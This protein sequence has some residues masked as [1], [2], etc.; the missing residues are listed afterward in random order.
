MVGRL[1]QQE[2]IGLSHHAHGQDKPHAEPSRQLRDLGGL[3]VLGEAHIIQPVGDILVGQARDLTLAEIHRGKLLDL[4]Q[5]LV[6][7][8]DTLQVRRH[9]G[10]AS[11]THLVHQ[12]GLPGTVAA[13]HTVSV[14]LQQL[15]SGVTEQQL[16]TTVA[17]EQ[18]LHAAQRGFAFTVL[19]FRA[20]QLHHIL[21]SQGQLLPLLVIQEPDQSVVQGLLHSEQALACVGHG[22]AE[23]PQV[24][25][26]LRG[27]PLH[28]G[29]GLGHLSIQDLIGLRHTLQISL[30]H[31][32]VVGGKGLLEVGNRA[33]VPLG[34]AIALVGLRVPH[35]VLLQVSERSGGEG[36]L[37]GCPLGELPDPARHVADDGRESV[38]DRLHRNWP[39]PVD[40]PS[41]VV[42][43][44]RPTDVHCGQQTA[45]LVHGQG[46]LALQ[47]ILSPSQDLL[48]CPLHQ[49]HGVHST[50]LVLI[51]HACL[52]PTH[53]HLGGPVGEPPHHGLRRPPGGS[54]HV[55]IGLGR[56]GQ[57]RGEHERDEGAKIVL[58]QV[59]ARVQDLEGSSAQQ[60]A[61]IRLQA[62]GHRTCD[63]LL[64][65]IRELQKAIGEG[66]GCPLPLVNV[67]RLQA[68]KQPRT[69]LSVKNVGHVRGQVSNSCGSLP[70][71]LRGG[72][73]HRLLQ[74][75]QQQG[76]VGPDGILAVH[77][78]KHRPGNACPLLLG[79]VGSLPEGPL[80]DGHNEGQGPGVDVV[81]EGGVGQLAQ[82]G[83]CQLLLG[84]VLQSADQQGREGSDLRVVNGGKHLLA[85]LEGGVN[86]F[87]SDVL[88]R[89][90]HNGQHDGGGGGHR[91]AVGQIKPSPRNALDGPHL[92]LPLGGG[93]PLDQLRHHK[94]PN[95]VGSGLAGDGLA[96]CQGGRAGAGK[97]S[98]E[99]LG[100]HWGSPSQ[101]GD[102]AEANKLLFLILVGKLLLDLVPNTELKQGIDAQVAGLRPELAG[103]S[104]L[105]SLSAGRQDGGILRFSAVH[106]GRGVHLHV[107]SHPTVGPLVSLHN[108][109][110]GDSGG[111]LLHGLPLKVGLVLLDQRL[112][113]NVPLVLLVLLH[114]CGN[115]LLFL[116]AC[117][118]LHLLLQIVKLHLRLAHQLLGRGVVQRSKPGLSDFCGGLSRRISSRCLC[119]GLG[120]WLS[121]NFCFRSHSEAGGGDMDSAL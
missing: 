87:T 101:P 97:G 117:A 35:R 105:G 11:S 81:H 20:A 77:Q 102:G 107:L 89:G 106:S 65:A 14:I 54:A 61:H 15:Q 13:H 116:C 104:H 109:S 56:P 119:R 95:G 79:L 28:V 34:R 110:G 88:Q 24:L 66:P 62:C 21:N 118:P 43:G 78:D 71:N 49:T 45:P 19:G 48:D 50:A 121:C 5:D 16:T 31:C 7:H 108:V 42:R 67:L 60:G 73:H 57:H 75:G 52:K 55:L 113:L 53:Q 4:L 92:D 22:G 29:H 3:Q 17:Q 93:Q 86:D 80:E 41:D 9:P 47:E 120:G 1:I 51:G 64:T 33:T 27:D 94:L 23:N 37:R 63:H 32:S 25:L 76:H 91:G 36:L 2:H 90:H 112:G 69:E 12:G 96:G 103:G 99:E 18:R 100:D 82:C 30:V 8:V 85:S 114:F 98:G 115:P 44:I 40:C 111:L 59:R 38:L 39:E 84:R 58:Q 26:H 6:L 68:S 10:Q 74:Q 46:T 72:V 70:L 83:P